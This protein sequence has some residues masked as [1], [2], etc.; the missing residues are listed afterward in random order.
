MIYAPIKYKKVSST[1]PLYMHRMGF[2]TAPSTEIVDDRKVTTSHADQPAKTYKY[3]VLKPFAKQTA[4]KGKRG[5]WGLKK[6]TDANK[7]DT[8]QKIQRPQKDTRDPKEDTTKRTDGTKKIVADTTTAATA[9]CDATTTSKGA[10]SS[11]LGSG[12]HTKAGTINKIKAK[13]NAV[14]NKKSSTKAQTTTESKTTAKSQADAATQATPAC[15]QT[16]K[17]ATS[18]EVKPDAQAFGT[19]VDPQTLSAPKTNTKSQKTVNFEEPNGA[20]PKNRQSIDFEEQKPQDLTQTTGATTA[21]NTTTNEVDNNADVKS[22]TNAPAVE[23]STNTTTTQEYAG[24][25]VS[26]DASSK[27]STQKTI[28]GFNASTE[29]ITTESSKKTQNSSRLQKISEFFGRSNSTKDPNESFFAR[30]KARL[31]QLIKPKANVAKN[32]IITQNV[33][34]SSVQMTLDDYQSEVDVVLRALALGVLKNKV[35]VDDTLKAMA[36]GIMKEQNSNAAKDS[37]RAKV[38]Q[39]TT[40][41]A[42]NEIDE[43]LRNIAIAIAENNPTTEQID[44]TLLAMATAILNQKEKDSFDP[45]LLSIAE[46]IQDTLKNEK[47]TQNRDTLKATYKP[48]PEEREVALNR[49]SDNEHTSNYDNHSNGTLTT[50]CANTEKATSGKIY[51]NIKSK[52]ASASEKIKR[53]FAKKETASTTAKKV[54]SADANVT[55][56]EQK[57]AAASHPTTTTVNTTT[58]TK[59]TTSSEACTTATSNKCRKRKSYYALKVENTKNAIIKAGSRVK[60]GLKRVS[61]KIKNYFA[62]Q[63]IELED[64]D[65]YRKYGM[66][67]VQIVDKQNNSTD[68][69]FDLSST[70]RPT[71]LDDFII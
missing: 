22:T 34:G 15:A 27:T 6:N 68:E 71:T 56:K 4:N 21:Q 48:T 24:T 17:T 1:S 53:F 18:D 67:Q 25:T 41:D 45:V 66:K 43:D 62:P 61:C 11:T 40:T 9:T 35:D 54:E 49:T 13:F 10:T 31:A 46:A 63:I 70:K 14:I 42:F 57:T 32:N 26:H 59:T 65:D 58:P 36:L 3:V 52:I 44:E 30:L 50:G 16:T 8:V 60:A 55:E 19:R 29:T 64:E 33:S 12:N 28:T 23:P 5:L 39:K 7:T 51:S 47:P 38:S 69:E 37:T 2:K 20:T